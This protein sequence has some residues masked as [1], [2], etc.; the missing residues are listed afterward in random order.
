MSTKQHTVPR[1][2]QKGFTLDRNQRTTWLMRP[3][4]KPEI[5]NIKTIW[6]R[7][8]AYSTSETADAD[9]AISGPQAEGKILRTLTQLRQG[10][11]EIQ[12]A[13][14]GALVSHLE[15]RGDHVIDNLLG[16]R[17]MN[18]VVLSVIGEDAEFEKWQKTM[19]ETV[20]GI[21]EVT[22]SERIAKELEKE[23]HAQEQQ[24]E[25]TKRTA[26]SL[27]QTAKDIVTTT[28]EE[29][30]RGIQ[31]HRGMQPKHIV[32][33]VRA[34]H[35]AKDPVVQ[36]RAEQFAQM[37]WRLRRVPCAILGTSMVFYKVSGRNE[38]ASF[39]HDR[40]TIEGV[41]VP[42]KTNLVL[43][44]GENGISDRDMRLGAARTSTEGFIS[45]RIP[46]DRER[47]EAECGKD[48]HWF[49]REQ[50]WRIAER[51]CQLAGIPVRPE[52]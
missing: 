33:A 21:G 28:T 7:A 4:R 16:S 50:Y 25:I 46:E 2:L 10:E 18:D 5:R 11:G 1:M 8:G 38:Y 14:I 29:R 3:G 31:E 35:L 19:K 20:V 43:V 13:E 6:K 49:T 27:I 42:I 36:N 24:H 37:D 12:R 32:R 51:V 39:V 23:G 30:K 47:L 26:L 40:K 22:E 15:T 48:V 9:G 44:G 52:A 17:A 45:S 41:Y 34:K